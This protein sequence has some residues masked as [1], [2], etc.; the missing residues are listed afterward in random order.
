MRDEEFLIE[1][2]KLLGDSIRS[3]RIW[4]IGNPLNPSVIK[5]PISRIGEPGYVYIHKPLGNLTEVNARP[6][7]F[8]SPPEVAKLPPGLISDSLLRFGLYVEVKREGKRLV[9]KGTES[10]LGNEYAYGIQERDQRPTD[11]SLFLPGLIWPTVPASGKVIIN[12]FPSVLDGAV[13]WTDVLETVDLIDTYA[14]GTAGQAVGVMLEV[15][16]VTSTIYYTASSAFTN[17]TIADPYT[18]HRQAFSNYPTSVDDGRFFLGYVKVYAGQT[19]ILLPDILPAQEV[20]SK[21]ASASGGNAAAAEEMAWIG[22]PLEGVATAKSLARGRIPDTK[23]T[24]YTAPTNT[25]A[26]IT[27]VMM[28][29]YYSSVDETVIL[30]AKTAGGT[31]RVIDYATL[32]P[33]ETRKFTPQSPLILEDEAELEA[34]STSNNLVT[35]IASGGE[36][37]TQ[38]T[39]VIVKHLYDGQLSDVNAALATLPADKKW[40]ISGIYLHLAVDPGS[41]L[42]ELVQIAVNNDTEADAYF[43][44][45]SCLKYRETYQL[46]PGT[47]LDDPDDE[48]FGGA[49]TAGYV[50]IWVDGVEMD[51]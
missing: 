4:C 7:E 1:G 47:I 42:G 51:A 20:F 35:F 13:R 29:N 15:D 40:L 23:G 31:S 8:N 30:Y 21:G 49:E 19:E 18:A 22:W 6:A 27:S 50:D 32:H 17:P 45:Y 10:I 14:P 25:T 36:R 39:G 26:R 46:F 3:S 11:L 37:T 33:G 28:C 44:F 43:I 16:P 5:V 41:N 9:I 12:P 34:E 24:L 38:T 48:L 2:Q